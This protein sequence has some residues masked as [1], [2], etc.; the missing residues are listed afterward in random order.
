M[1]KIS[2][3]AVV[4]LA[5]LIIGCGSSNNGAFAARSAQR[6]SATK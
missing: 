2:Y 1:N 5:L 4:I 3:A 6:R